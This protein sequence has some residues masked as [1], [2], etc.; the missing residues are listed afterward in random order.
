VS[1]LTTIFHYDQR[2][3]LIAESDGAGSVTTEYVYLNGAPLAKFEGASVYYYSTDH[4]ST[5]QKMTDG[6]G[7]VV[8][9][10]DYK[11]FGE[12]TITVSTITNNLR[13]PGQYYD[14]E[15]GLNYN[16]YRDYS[17]QL[18]RYVEADPIGIKKGKNHLFVY[19][20]NNTLRY[21]DPLGLAIWVCNRKTTFGVGNH[22][23]MWD[24]RTG[25]C[26]GMGSTSSCS[27]KGLTGGD[28]CNKVPGSDGREGELLSCCKKT[29]DKGIWFPPVNDCHE[30]VGDCLKESGIKN[31]G[32]PGGRVGSPCDKKC[33]EPEI[34]TDNLLN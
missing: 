31:P 5:P 33:P 10:A 28:D 11:P 25:A 9:A 27:E 26:C 32:A 6:T 30:A 2:G 20:R 16:Y 1:G 14:A 13:F 23:Y 24:D 22:A 15:T 12:A 19:A 4:L 17:S 3:Q 7:A 29:A 18:D 8:W 21:A 34:D